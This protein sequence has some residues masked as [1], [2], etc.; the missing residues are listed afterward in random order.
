MRMGRAATG[1]GVILLAG[2]CASA[3]QPLGAGGGYEDKRLEKDTYEV[4]FVGQ[5]NTPRPVVLKYFL[6]RCA[7]LTLEQDYEY[8]E[9]YAVGRESPRSMRDEEGRF[10]RARSAYRGPTI[11]YVPG[12]ATITRWQVTGVIR[13]YPKDI[14]G[15]AAEL[16]SAREVVAL[17]GPEVRSGSPGIDIPRKL[18]RVEGKFPVAPGDVRESVPPPP[19]ADGPVRLDDLK[20]LLPR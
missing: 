2:A 10:I 5:G 6:Y 9:I 1:V 18:K 4:R 7:E 12:Q 8:F 13:M 20:E 3:Y 19:A 17:L 11:V 15:D 16:F 14:L